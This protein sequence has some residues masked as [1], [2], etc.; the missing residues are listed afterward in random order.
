M[1]ISAA[2]G[3]G[4]NGVRRE[5]DKWLAD[6]KKRPVWQPKKET[7][8]QITRASGWFIKIPNKPI[9]ASVF[10]IQTGAS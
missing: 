4:E 2:G 3:V 9:F 5:I 10:G 7:D 6:W 8:K 1:V